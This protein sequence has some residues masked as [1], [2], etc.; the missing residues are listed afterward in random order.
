MDAA[1]MLCARLR[2]ALLMYP[3]MLIFTCSPFHRRPDMGPHGL[4]PMKRIWSSWCC[5][6]TRCRWIAAFHPVP[7]SL[8]AQ[9]VAQTAMISIL[10]QYEA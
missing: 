6:I 2:L 5:Q 4:T 1:P 10:P 3:S 8:G 7:I 9:T